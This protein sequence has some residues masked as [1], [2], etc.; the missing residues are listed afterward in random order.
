MSPETRLILASNR[1]PFCI[2]HDSRDVTLHATSGGLAAALGAVHGR[3]DHRWVGWPG[4][5]SALDERQ[6]ARLIAELNRRRVVPVEVA[7]EERQAYYDGVCNSVLWPVFHGL[8]D[9]LPVTLPDIRAY[10][11]VNERFADAIAA[12]YRDGDVVWIHDYHLM[13]A[14]AMVRA[15]LP[16]ARIGFF[17]HTPFPPADIFR[18]LP[19]RREL[20]DGVL[21]S[22]LAGFQTGRDAANFAA[23][24]RA[25]TEYR[26]DGA[27][28]IADRRTIR[29]GAYPIGIDPMRLEEARRA[30]TAAPHPVLARVGRG[31]K[32]LVGVDRLDYTKGITRRLAAVE[33]VF[34]QEPRLRGAISLLQIA[35]PSRGDVP[36]YAA[37]AQE[38]A[39]RV[40]RI[41]ARFGTGEWTPVHYVAESLSAADLGAVYRAADVML[42]TSLRD[43]MNLVAKEFVSA[44][45]DEDGVLILSELAGAA[46]E[47]RDA[48]IVNPYAIDEVADCI[49][50]ALA[51]DR[52]ER[53][54]RMRSLRER[55]AAR[56]IDRWVDRFV[57]DL[58]A[59]AAPG[60]PA[61]R[62]VVN[63]L[64]L[65]AADEARH[66][67]V[68]IAPSGL[69]IAMVYEEALVEP[70]G[71]G[72]EARPDPELLQLLGAL[73]TRAR[74][75]LHVISA[76][77]H[78][79]LGPWFEM[80]PVTI[81]SEDGLW[82]RD[83]D[84]RRWRRAA[85]VDMEWAADV[86]EFLD[87]F[88]A[89][90][91]G[92]F[93][94]ERSTG[95]RWH[96]GRA[97][98]VTGRARAQ[99]LFALLQDASETLAFVV[100]M[101]PAAIALR[102]AA[103]SRVETIRRIL[104]GDAGRRLAVFE[105]GRPESARG[106]T[107]RDILRPAD[108]LVTVGTNGVPAS[109]SLPDRR[110]VRDV[111]QTI[112]RHQPPA[113]PCSSA[114]SALE[115]LAARAVASHVRPFAVAR[116]IAVTPDR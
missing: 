59:A 106:L 15:H 25:L 42:V 77:D 18:V 113:V 16:E 83:R 49:I 37:Y 91:P 14:P 73:A 64:R 58:T 65:S 93:V 9:R 81:W 47:L 76:L 72:E 102:P 108:V 67:A 52:D 13:L 40:A 112:A 35:V 99:E 54:R 95:L 44:R 66:G 4:D 68:S 22:S 41:N 28:I 27:A 97:D 33:R 5:S 115:A 50:S 45:S 43:G 6:H 20:L 3:G 87:H 11:D 17:L 10:R 39:E 96:F 7:A 86:R 23:A 19:W 74:I 84:E 70:A 2:E 92:A 69:S 71:A 46:D 61:G 111:L 36:S 31:T 53:R 57:A 107:L 51:F 24:V 48:V 90:T 109:A 80:V 26:V 1:L 32:L 94:E 78:A 62:E 63:L 30:S 56:P 103:L 101:T 29:F 104:D 34:A 114:A 12:T 38:V 116:E 85:C 75:D 98:R 79:T 55:V 105:A 110:A 100:T 8:I 89:R 21:G 60:L 88:T 82:R